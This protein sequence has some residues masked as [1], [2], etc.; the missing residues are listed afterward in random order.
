MSGRVH[1]TEKFPIFTIY[2]L[3]SRTVNRFKALKILDCWKRGKGYL[4]QVGADT[5]NFEALSKEFALIKSVGLSNLTNFNNSTAYGE[6]RSWNRKEVSYYGDYLLI[7]TL[8]YGL[9]E[10]PAV[11][12]Q[13]DIF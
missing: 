1:E 2:L 5:D 3:F 6:M 9:I 13:A 12:H 7:K 8:L 4:V 11:N 10:R